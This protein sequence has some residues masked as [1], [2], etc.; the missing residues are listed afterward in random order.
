MGF[1]SRTDREV[2]PLAVIGSWSQASGLILDQ[3]IE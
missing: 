3:L 1:L 2:E